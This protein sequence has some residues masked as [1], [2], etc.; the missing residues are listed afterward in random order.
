MIIEQKKGY[1]LH[2]CLHLRSPSPNKTPNTKNIFSSWFGDQSAGFYILFQLKLILL[3]SV[4]F[5]ILL[6]SLW[7]LFVSPSQLYVFWK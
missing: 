5:S 3:V 7:I 6:K 2:N 1:D 4:R